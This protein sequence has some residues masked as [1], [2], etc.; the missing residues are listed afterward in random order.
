[1]PVTKSIKLHDDQVLWPEHKSLEEV[2][3]LKETTIPHV[4]ETTYQGNDV[5]PGGNM[6]Q[7]EWFP[8]FAELR[9]TGIQKIAGRWISLDT[10]LSDTENSARSAAI[11][12]DLTTDYRLAVTD[13]WAEHVQFPQLINK[14]KELAY[15]HNHDGKLQGVVI[16]KKAS[17]FS[18]IQVLRQSADEWLSGMI[19][20]YTPT[21][22]KPMRW[23]E[24]SLWCS[25]GMVL[26]PNPGQDFPWLFDFEG[27]LRDAPDVDIT[28]RLDAFAQLVIFLEHYLSEG[29][30]AR[31]GN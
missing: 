19:L 5:V 12:G 11:V 17:G 15:Q 31:R 13:C 7:L 29:Y 8:R 1:M 6:F 18:L 16:E 14:T 28:D 3:L 25:L 22:S 30:H 23:G 20:E 4:W 27:D 9:D 26:L 24:A 2:L 21:Y 10:G